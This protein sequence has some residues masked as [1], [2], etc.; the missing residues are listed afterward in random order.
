MDSTNV[1][2]R[3]LRQL[4]EEQGLS[5]EA[6]AAR[7]REESADG[8]GISADAVKKIES[9][10]VQA[11]GVGTLNV[12]AAALH[13]D[14]SWLLDRRPRLKR[15][16]EHGVLAV[17]DALTDPA[18]LPGVTLDEAGTPA[19][20]EALEAAVATGWDAY[21]AGQLGAL[22][23]LLP[24]L[25]G[26]VRA[27]REH[28]GEA[29][30]RPAAQ[31]FQLAADWCVH[32]GYDDLA[33]ATAR[34]AVRAAGRSEGTE[35]HDPLQQAVLSST[36]SWILLHQGRLVRAEEI[37]A[38]AADTLRPAGR[39]PLDQRAVRGAL[40]LSAAAPAATRGDE[41]AVT[42]YMEEARM[43]ALHF[44]AGDSHA[45]Q[46]SMGPSQVAMQV[47]YTSA[48]LRRFPQAAAAAR[49][50]N[51]GDLLAISFGAHSLDVAAAELGMADRARRRMQHVEAGV[52]ALW[53]AQAVSREWA[54]QQPQFRSLVGVAVKAE[55]K[56]SDR[57]E[58]LA[59]IAG[60]RRGISS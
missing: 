48:V 9:G 6:L 11:P 15:D 49:R 25:I 2:G 33:M 29:V 58:A 60:L 37:A 32:M 22:T 40:L 47:T 14:L 46:V 59:V 27:S 41:A 5:R 52:D 16:R 34:R 45:Y 44:T 50:V 38:A 26:S 57:T 13:A 36:L 7:T 28:L 39:V 17:R 10:D 1:I 54:A 53:E 19:S 35:H 23:T 31:V 21:W 30:A 55:R 24:S 3:R 56:L 20:L 51:R 42:H 12:L 43:E 18:D 8:R 4:R